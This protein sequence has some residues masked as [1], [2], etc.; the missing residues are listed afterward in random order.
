M[1]M[2]KLT[3]M[4]VLIVMLIGFTVIIPTN[5]QTNSDL[6]ALVDGN[7]EFAFDLY[8]ELANGNDDN[9]I[10]S[11]YS[12]SVAMAM[13]YAGAHQRR[14]PRS[15]SPQNREKLATLYGQAH[16]AQ[17]PHLHAAHVVDLLEALDFDNGFLG[18]G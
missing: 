4:T 8:H 10:F 11:P 6:T 5:S 16:A 7:T 13:L 14:F 9:L 17:G 12:I 18:H 15:R 1:Y 2:R 3:F